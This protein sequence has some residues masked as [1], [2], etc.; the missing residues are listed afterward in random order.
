MIHP[1]AIVEASAR[2]D[3]S[4][5]I[6]PY[7]IVGADVEIGPNTIIAAHVAIS[8]PTRI[9]R[10]NRIYQF[11]SIGEDPQDK[12][13]SRESES[14]LEIGDGNVIREYCSLNRGTGEGGGITRVGDC[15]WIMAYVH[16]AHDCQ[17]GNNNTFANNATLAGHV[18]I[19]DF[20]TLGGFTGVHQFCHI[21]SYAFTA[22]SS[23]IVKDIPPYLMVTGNTAKPCG[24]NKEGL[25]RHGFSAD[26]INS[27]RR[28]Y[29]ILYRD[30]LM[31]N[32]AMNKLGDLTEEC[33]D[34]MPFLDFIRQSRRGIVR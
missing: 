31:L 26:A 28:A 19:D 27:I 1:T 34:I 25:K 10:D 21:G 33:N 32:Q 18:V 30:G 5:S 9:G 6:G 12:K 2:I 20:V 14:I 8:G 29:R 3:E 17:I 7:S 11:C 24:L 4:V 16:I 23:V 13:F 15:N 22:I